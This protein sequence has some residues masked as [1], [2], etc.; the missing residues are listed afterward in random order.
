MKP[1]ITDLRKHAAQ[2]GITLANPSNIAESAIQTILTLHENDLLQIKADFDDALRQTEA[3]AYRL[4]QTHEERYIVEVLELLVK[5]V[6]Q[7]NPG[8]NLDSFPQIFAENA[9]LLDRFYLSL[10]QGRKARAGKAFEDFHNSLFSK[11]GY[12]FD[13]QRVING[14]PDFIL[15]SENH[16]R[17]D[18]M[19][20]IIFT[21][22]RT[23]RERW[24]QVVTEGARGRRF[25][26]A[27]I[28]EKI[29]HVQ[30]NEMLEHGIT[31][32]CP[33][34]IK[35]TQYRLNAN[36]LSFKE[37]FED[38]LDPALVRWQ[39]KGIV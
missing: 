20:C 11:L 16:Y 25:F 39:R 34:A 23:L 38:Y 9:N 33:A 3:E 27:T 22:K 35:Q 32:V 8:I 6:I 4:Y 21:A 15:P 5:A 1:A 7:S 14:K 26:I 18:P 30:L 37:F 36:V 31:I 24:R 2:H 29:T 12:P 13:S 19:D 28:D 10:G 17:N